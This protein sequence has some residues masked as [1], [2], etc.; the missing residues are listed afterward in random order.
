MSTEN[1]SP[2]WRQSQDSGNSANQ[3]IIVIRMSHYLRFTLNFPVHF[4]FFMLNCETSLSLT[5]EITNRIID[6]DEDR[7]DLLLININLTERRGI[8]LIVWCV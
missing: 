2:Q 4:R 6:L 3:T 7:F 8:G 1:R 5:R